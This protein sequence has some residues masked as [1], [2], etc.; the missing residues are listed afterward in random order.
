MPSA[1]PPLYP[2]TSMV[3]C[4]APRL[5][6]DRVA[7]GLVGADDEGGQLAAGGKSS[8]AAPSSSRGGRR[9]RPAARRPLPMTRTS[10][11]A[12]SP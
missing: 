2:V 9:L 6:A 3:G 4:W 5:A 12:W 7:E 1:R 10:P 11:S 8:P